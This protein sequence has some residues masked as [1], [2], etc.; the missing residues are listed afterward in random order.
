MAKPNKP[1]AD[2]IRTLLD[3]IDLRIRNLRFAESVA[4]AGAHAAAQRSDDATCNTAG[5][6]A[7]RAIRA[8]D[9][10][11]RRAGRLARAE[12]RA[13]QHAGA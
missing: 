8:A 4:Y 13:L 1:R 2:R 5:H 9:T 11:N 10:L 12:L 7:V 6:I 3:R